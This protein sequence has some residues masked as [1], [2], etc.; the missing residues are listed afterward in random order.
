MALPQNTATLIQFLR[1]GADPSS[2]Y[3]VSSIAGVISIDEYNG[4]STEPTEQELTDAAADSTLVDHGDGLE[5]FTTWHNKNG[6]DA[7]LTRKSKVKKRIDTADEIGSAQLAELEQRNKR[8]NY[9]ATRLEQLANRVQAML[10]STG[11]VANMRTDGL[12]V[13]VSPINTRP[14][15]DAVSDYKDAVDTPD[16]S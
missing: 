10:D 1:P 13:S 11:G 7:T 15:P 3:S 8:D 12:A 5:N 14:R 16:P 2:D 6:G 4:P 9:L